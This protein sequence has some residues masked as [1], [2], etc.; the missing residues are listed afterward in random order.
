MPRC[1]RLDRGAFLMTSTKRYNL[2]D[3]N[4]THLF[5]QHVIG[6]PDRTEQERLAKKILEAEFKRQSGPTSGT[7]LDRHKRKHGFSSTAARA[8]LRRQIVNELTTQKRPKRDEDLRLGPG[9]GGA[10]PRLGEPKC[11]RFACVV[12]GAPASGKSSISAMI[13]DETSAVVIDADYAKR[14]LPEYD[15]GL[16]ADLVHAESSALVEGP[17][18]LF[19]W[20]A[21]REQNLVYVLV[22]RDQ[23]KVQLHLADLKA[24]GYDVHLV[25]TVVKPETAAKRALER[26]DRDGRYVPLDYIYYDVGT[27]PGETIEALKISPY[28]VSHG[29]IDTEGAVG[30]NTWLDCNGACEATRLDCRCKIHA[31]A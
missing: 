5:L 26:F 24:L 11:S 25:G 4:E 15:N 28:L 16:G 29:A 18:G 1:G 12:L 6:I 14:K 30:D 10:L 22:G 7:L 31:K 3:V 2:R 23:Q 19:E 21:E 13:A 17:G 27:R 20:V 9:G 8:E